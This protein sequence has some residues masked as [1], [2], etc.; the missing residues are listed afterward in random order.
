M[1]WA[2][3]KSEG[4]HR[5]RLPLAHRRDLKAK[6]LHLENV[7]RQAT[8]FDNRT[9]LAEV[10]FGREVT[11]LMGRQCQRLADSLIG[12]RYCWPRPPSPATR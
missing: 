1:R 4:C 12:G 11:E 3:P 10:A 6:F 8:S 5:T 9:R 2:L 7:A